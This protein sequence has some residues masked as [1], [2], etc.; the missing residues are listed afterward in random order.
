MSIEITAS[1]PFKFVSS[2]TWDTL[3][4][5][6]TWDTISTDYPSWD[7][8][9]GTA[10][11]EE[12]IGSTSQIY[13]FGDVGNDDGSAIAALWEQYRL[14]DLKLRHRVDALETFFKQNSVAVT[15]TVALGTTDTVATD[16]SYPAELTTTFDIGTDARHQ[17]DVATA[18][19][20]TGTGT[21]AAQFVAVKHT[22]AATVP[23]EWR[24][25]VLYSFPEEIS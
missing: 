22:M 23:W 25:S 1:W 15:V 4:V 13:R 10:E 17:L 5:A 7:S 12:L 6:W 20:G 18:T 11:P 8:F 21:P 2:L 3:P 14:S 16:A 9:P 24:G 19:T